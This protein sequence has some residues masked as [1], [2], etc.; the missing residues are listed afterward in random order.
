MRYSELLQGLRATQIPIAEGGW[1]G[2]EDMHQDYAVIALDGAVDMM[3][4][5]G[6]SER[7]VEGS[8][9]LFTYHSMGRG[10]AEIIEHTMEALGVIWRLGYGPHYEKDTGF[11]HY[12]WIFQCLPG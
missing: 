1:D 4:N 5:N 11:T 9:D 2:A 7:M 6:H 10:K 12:E 8:I 3:A